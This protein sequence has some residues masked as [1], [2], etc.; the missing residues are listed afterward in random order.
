MKISK[1]FYPSIL[2]N[3]FSLASS[4]SPVSRL[5]PDVSSEEAGTVAATRAGGERT[6]FGVPS[7][8]LEEAIQRAQDYLVKLQHAD[9]YWVAELEANTTLT[10]EYIFFLHM[11]GLV[12]QRRIEKAANYLLQ[13]QQEDGGWNI[14]HGG[15]S[16]LSQ[17]VEA[18]FAL[19][20][21]GKSPED[22]A[23]QKARH[24]ILSQ[25][26]IPQ[27]RVFT[28]IFLALFGQYDWRGIPSMPVEMILFP[29]GFYFNL[30]EF[31]S[32]SRSVII[33]LLVIMAKR[34]RYPL[35][36]GAEVDELYPEPRQGTCYALPPAARRLSWHNLFLHLDSLLKL[37]EKRPL[38]RLRQRAM[39]EAEHWILS[40]QDITGDWGGIM[41]AMMNSI[42]ALHCLGYPLSHPVMR[43]G[44]EAI[45]RFGIEEEDH[46]RLQSC[47]SP[48][49][50]TAISTLALRYAGL[51]PH[52][53]V[54]QKA[55]YWLLQKQ[56]FRG[57]D[58]RVKN[59][60]GRP[61][62]WAF[63]FA[64]DFYPDN[65]DTA[66]VLM[67][68]QQVDLP[69]A[70]AAGLQHLLSPEPS[71][72]EQRVAPYDK[73][74]AMERGVEWL[75]SMQG[76]DGGWG[77]FDVDNNKRLLNEIPFADEKALI[78]PS[79]S[80]LTGRVL[81]MLGRL[82]YTLS[83]PPARRALRFLQRDQHPEGPWYGRWG[84][85]YIYGTWAVL[86]GLRAIGENMQLPYVRKAVEWL[87]AHQNEDGG[88]GESC[89]SYEDFRHAGQGESTAS[90]T[91][92]A[93]MG[94]VAAGE[95]H[96]QAVQRGVAY[97]IQTQNR[98]GTWEEE[99]YTGTGFPGHF[100]IRYHLYRHYFPLMA[101]AK[102]R[103]V[104]TTGK[105]SPP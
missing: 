80:D 3:L 13:T 24:W 19:K 77:A 94:L 28:K 47:V 49:W 33:P 31:S 101:L 51:P 93:V 23:L 81:E 5:V 75:L 72:P 37:Y 48:V 71:L 14:Y 100:Y 11:L 82:G 30:Y 74:W 22:P 59:R 69:V 4:P 45:E 73:A 65:D 64:N 41:P 46:F 26:G 53:P 57:G 7:S 52:H 39:V 89:L 61:G 102:V 55:G 44:L 15:P 35:P 78:D 70:K 9:G 76:K 10:S 8:H 85:N 58:W 97:L 17:T 42:L 60:T 21:A 43:K 90:Q 87:K 40:H 34:P 27:A 105:H 98:E 83:F 18:Y 62:G 67:A 38:S 91:A 25:G 92:W 20:L 16:R 86:E 104:L 84:V 103:N 2:Q 88:W 32:W 54:L 99:A 66:M 36:P 96:S 68:L 12:D 1:R 56:I 6:R 95:V 63:E 79:T 50:D 29:Q